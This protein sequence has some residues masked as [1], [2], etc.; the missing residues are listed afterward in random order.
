MAELPIIDLPMELPALPGALLN[1]LIPGRIIPALIPRYSSL[2][3]QHVTLKTRDYIGQGP[4]GPI[5]VPG[6]TL[7][8]KL[9]ANSVSP[10]GDL[11]EFY[12]YMRSGDPEAFV[13]L[14]SGPSVSEGL[15]QCAIS[16]SCGAT[17]D[18]LFDGQ[19]IKDMPQG[20]DIG[21]FG[22]AFVLASGEMLKQ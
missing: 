1:E 14:W 19:Q 10:E 8:P 9:I 15:V 5:E 4:E 18:F 12:V 3:S 22:F 11:H 17:L 2:L 6:V 20:S 7:V 13:D 21:Y 16:R